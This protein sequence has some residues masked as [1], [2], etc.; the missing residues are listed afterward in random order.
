MGTNKHN[1][2]SLKLILDDPEM[3]FSSEEKRIIGSIARYHRNGVPKENHYNLACLDKEIKLKIKI[4]SGILR[5][6]DALDFTHHSIVE[7]VTAS[8][9]AKKINIECVVND[10]PT[11]EEKAVDKKKEL[12]EEL[13][14]K[15]LVLTWRKK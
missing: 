12:L 3:P 15:K 7:Q 9:D 11:E 14:G 10:S 2:N 13:F 1:K 4:L 8:A 5:V 6:A